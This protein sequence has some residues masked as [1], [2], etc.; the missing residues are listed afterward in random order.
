VQLKNSLRMGG[1]KG[2]HERHSTI[3]RLVEAFVP[4]VRVF[5]AGLEH[6]P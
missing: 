1:Q 6:V 3:H 2:E 5:R 4:G